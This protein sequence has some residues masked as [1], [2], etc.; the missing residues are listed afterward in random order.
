M[1]KDPIREGQP[2]GKQQE[3]EVPLFPLLSHFSMFFSI[4]FLCCPHFPLFPHVSLFC[5]IHRHP[6]CVSPS[7]PLV[8]PRS[9]GPDGF[10][11]KTNKETNRPMVSLSGGFHPLVPC[12]RVF[13]SVGPHPPHSPPQQAVLC[14]FL[15]PFK[16]QPQK[17][18]RKKRHTM[19]VLWMVPLVPVVCP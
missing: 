8:K 4:V 2:K 17:G 11:P 19:C 12:G 1:G 9:L 5:S 15:S 16:Q 14:S 13:D 18:T 6:S 3:D 10:Q 7:H